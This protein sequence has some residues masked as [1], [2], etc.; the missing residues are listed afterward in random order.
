MRADLDLNALRLRA[1]TGN[2]VH[3]LRAMEHLQATV[4]DDDLFRDLKF[5]VL[6]PGPHGDFVNVE[7]DFYQFDDF[8]DETQRRL[9]SIVQALGEHL[10]EA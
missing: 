10:P 9:L 7:M 2:R 6:V 8:M 3:V 5:T 4:L 1:V